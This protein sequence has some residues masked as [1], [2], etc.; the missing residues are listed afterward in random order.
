M[1]RTKKED[2]VTFTKSELISKIEEFL[3]DNH[4]CNGDWLKKAK[5]AFLGHKEASYDVVVK[6]NATYTVSVASDG[7]KPSLSQ[8]AD[9]ILEEQDSGDFTGFE[10]DDSKFEVVDVKEIS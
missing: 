10:V 3:E 9:A 6:V 4:A 7:K 2:T 8:V 5:I 1:A